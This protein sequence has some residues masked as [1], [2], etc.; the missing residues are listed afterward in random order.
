MIVK[1]GFSVTVELEKI[2]RYNMAYK[3]NK[4]ISEDSLLM[5]IETLQ[6][7]LNCGKFTAKQIAEKARA[8]VTVG[9][10]VLYSREKIK[11]YLEQIAE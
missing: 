8:K 3:T 2:R 10:R 6:S 9:R 11:K 7:E 5:N 4:S 1:K